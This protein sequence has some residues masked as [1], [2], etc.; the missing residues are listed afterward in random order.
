MPLELLMKNN[1]REMDYHKYLQPQNETT[2]TPHDPDMNH[3]EWLFQKES[4]P[5][6]NKAVWSNE[7]HLFLISARFYLWG[8]GQLLCNDWMWNRHSWVSKEHK[9]DIF[10]VRCPTWSLL[11]FIDIFTAQRVVLQDT[12]SII[13][14]QSEI[15]CFIM[16]LPEHVNRQW[17][18]F[19]SAF[20]VDH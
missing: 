17:P 20:P 18:N 3:A 2:D 13:P 15:I 6:F 5:R 4:E 11:H 10:C 16:E 8:G 14:Q 12:Y 9:R 1:F 7:I 19:I